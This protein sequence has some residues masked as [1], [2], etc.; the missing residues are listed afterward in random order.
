VPSN[1]RRLPDAVHVSKHFRHERHCAELNFDIVARVR[2]A[3]HFFLLWIKTARVES[4]KM[5]MCCDVR[6]QCT[7]LQNATLHQGHF[8][9]NATPPPCRA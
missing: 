1:S 5:S 6:R 9:G 4:P 3:S 8:L 7:Q 2:S